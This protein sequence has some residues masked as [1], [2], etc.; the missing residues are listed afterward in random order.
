MERIEG[1]AGC[2]VIAMATYRRGSAQN[3]ML[4]SITERVLTAT[5]L[6]LL[7]VRPR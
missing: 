7:M 2:D 1:A 5:K 6:P 3:W 4:G